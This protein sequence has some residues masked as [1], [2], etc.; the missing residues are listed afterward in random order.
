MEVTVQEETVEEVQMEDDVPELSERQI[1][2]MK[3]NVRI[4]FCVFQ[5]IILLRFIMLVVVDDCCTIM[6]PDCVDGDN[7]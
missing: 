4:L 3:K 5:L 6:V 1:T 7:V 2:S